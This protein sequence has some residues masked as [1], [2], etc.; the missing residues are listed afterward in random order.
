MKAL[1]V[2]DVQNDFCEGGSLAVAGGSAV[3]NSISV[4]VGFDR[5]GGTYDFAVATKDWHV[6]PGS[7]FADPA[8]G[9]NYVDTWPQHC[10]AGSE[11][12]AFHPN[13]NVALDEVFL[14]GRTSASYT[15]FDGGAVSDETVLLG[16][17]LASRA[18]VDV[19]V[20]GLAT[21]HCVKATALDAAAAGFNT[22]VLLEH[23]AGVAKETTEAALAQLKNAGVTLVGG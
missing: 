12:A 21:D 16:E 23:C 14:K 9:P 2:V 6:N 10:V 8:V 18:V 15:G 5:A 13:L 1:V 11:G 17:W 22:R 7:H 20:V 19:D 3:A 4:F